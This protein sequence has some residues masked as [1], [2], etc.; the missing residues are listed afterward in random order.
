MCLICS[1]H[2]ASVQSSQSVWCILS[3]THREYS[4]HQGF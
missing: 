3:H 1:L 4:T 2:L